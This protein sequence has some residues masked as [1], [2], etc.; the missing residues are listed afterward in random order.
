MSYRER[1][2]RPELDGEILCVWTHRIDG[3]QADSGHRVFPDGCID[4]V[5]HD[6]GPPVVVG[7]MTTGRVVRLPRGTQV[8]GVRLRPG[9]AQA[10]FDVSATELLDREIALREL[11]GRSADQLHAELLESRCLQIAIFQLDGKLAQR[12]PTRKTLDARLSFAIDHLVANPAIPIET[13]ATQAGLGQRQLR[14]LFVD[15]I[16]YGPKTL[17]RIFR[18]Q[19]AVA[20]FERAGNLDRSLTGVAFMAG[21]ADQAHFT[22]EVQLLTGAAPTVALPGAW[23]AIEAMSDSFKTLAGS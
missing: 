20:M 7:P 23:C 18:L 2:P 17:A 4:I 9:V 22:R 3:E 13:I 6:E 15:A 8:A 12:R 21:Y 14:R 19:R 10:W 16:G 11:W 5:W 1:P